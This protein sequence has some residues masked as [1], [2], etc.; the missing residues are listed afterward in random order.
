ML[1][2]DFVIPRYGVMAR[3]TYLWFQALEFGTWIIFKNELRF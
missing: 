3:I 1:A 2:Q